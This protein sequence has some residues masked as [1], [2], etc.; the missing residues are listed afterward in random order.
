MIESFIAVILFAFGLWYVGS[1]LFSQEK[2]EFIN[3][4]TD[5]LRL[6]NETVLSTLRDLELDYALRKIS[7]EQY[8]ELKNQAYEE[9]AE[10]LRKIDHA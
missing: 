5:D 8:Q 10:I 3:P 7:D 2:G 4:A 6:K 9:R 1:P